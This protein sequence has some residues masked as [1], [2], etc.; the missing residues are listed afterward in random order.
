MKINLTTSVSGNH[1]DV[2]ARFDIDLFKF[3]TPPFPKVKIH[4]FTGTEVGDDYHIEFLFPM[5]GHWKGKITDRNIDDDAAYFIDEGTVL[6]MGLSYW[7]H[8]H[9][10]RKISADKSDIIDQIE[11]KTRFS[12]LTLLMY[13][14]LYFSFALR[15]PLY[16]KYF[17]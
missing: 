15:G 9:I 5:K 7:H 6:P 8:K 13:P 1:R 4:A 11:F 16:R 12:L 17:R 10:V 3:L 2:M 14:V